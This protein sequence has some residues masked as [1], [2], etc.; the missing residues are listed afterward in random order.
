MGQGL[1]RY[2]AF[3]A[4]LAAAGLPI[5]IHAP[6]FYVDSYGVTLTQLTFALFLLR[7]LDVVQ[8]PLLARLSAMTASVRG[9][10]AWGAGAIM[11]LAMLGLFAME[12]L[13]PPIWWFAVTLAALFSGFSFLTICFYAQGVAKAAAMG[14]GHVRLASWRETG[15]L[16]GVCLAAALPALLAPTGA[17]FALYAVI[18][19]AAAL[20]ALWA[21]A[22]EWSGR[23]TPPAATGLGLVLGD[24]PARRLLLIALANATPVAVSS[25][26]FLF[27][28]EDRLDNAPAA[29]PLLLVFFLSAAAAAPL[30]GRAAA[31]WGAWRVLM[32]AM[33]LA[34]VVY[35]WALTLG[36]GDTWLFALICIGSGAAVGADLTLLPALFARRMEVIAPGAADGFG[37]WN[38]V[39]KIT[40]AFAAVTLFPILEASGFASGTENA[41]RALTTLTLLYAGVPLG[42][43]ALA[44]A[45][46]A[47]SGRD[48]KQ[49]TSHA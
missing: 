16:T 28:V 34:M 7:L 14:D 12:P 25:T 4:V 26:L 10:M 19:A 35:A 46:L 21:M 23:G 22:P 40:L 36:A 17:P 43:K 42:L 15:A 6:K 20:L 49:E 5:Y 38:F 44:L 29:G 13:L 8:D 39:N 33:V 27:F 9:P 41:P 47:R 48:L 37:L 11:A 32:A 24:P 1:P 31:R 2:A 18:F 45:L 3:A 30:W